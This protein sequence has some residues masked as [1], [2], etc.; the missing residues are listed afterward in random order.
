MGRKYGRVWLRRPWQTVEEN[1]SQELKVEHFEIVV[2]NEKI[3]LLVDVEVDLEYKRNG[4]YRTKMFNI[5]AGYE[6][7]GAS[8][9]P[10]FWG[11]IGEPDEPEF[12]IAALV[13]DYLY[14]KRWYRDMADAAFQELLEDAG[15]WSFKAALMYSVVRVGGHMFYAG[16]TSVFWRKVRNYFD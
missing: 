6:F 11:V 2:D 8:I 3:R 13:H 14:E 1:E 5:P 15:V 12:I 10:M 16:D 4:S 9:P 7:D